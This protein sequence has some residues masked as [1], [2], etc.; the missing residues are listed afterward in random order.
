MKTMPFQ[1]R[2]DP[3]GRLRAVSARGTLLGNRGILHDAQQ[4]I[5]AQWKSKGWVTCQLEFEGR[6]REVFSAGRYSQL[7][8]LDEA[9][10]FSAGHRPCAECRR[11]RHDKFKSAW[12]K[13]NP[14]LVRTA[15]PPIA[16][17]DKVMH[18][19][20]A[21]RGGGKITFEAA[22]ADLP[23]G[24]FIELGGEAVLVWRRGLLRW[25]FAGYSGDQIL[26]APST[27]VRVLTPASVVRVFRSG[28]VPTVHVSAESQQLAGKSE[29]RRGTGRET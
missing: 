5:V 20:R 25:S 18:A 14:G 8:F 11:A 19:E 26:L 16:E 3:W 28:F 7:F 22:L 12:V 27:P 29:S 17:M 15:N 9:T 10:A 2:V 21:L 6:K 23:P 1:N 4:E 13:A 24:T